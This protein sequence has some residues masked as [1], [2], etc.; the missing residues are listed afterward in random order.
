MSKERSFKEDLDL[1]I[2]LFKK[3]KDKT[4]LESIPG[5]DKNMYKSFDMFLS[6][7]EMMRDQI[8]EDLLQQFGEPMKKMI[9][10]LVQQMKN[11]L[12]SDFEQE[13]PSEEMI[14]LKRDIEQVDELLKN[15][16]L[17]EEEVNKLLDERVMLKN[18]KKGTIHLPESFEQDV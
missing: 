7:Y 11:E 12:G 18:D 1:L 16:G 13:E 2:R 15:P 14:A 5:I 9:A 17:S 8:S 10:D 3:L 6:N 4:P